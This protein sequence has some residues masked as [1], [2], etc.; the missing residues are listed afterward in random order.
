M[1]AVAA[2]LWSGKRPGLTDLVLT[3]MNLTGLGHWV[4]DFEG[5]IGTSPVLPLCFLARAAE[6]QLC[7]A[8]CPHHNVPP[9]VNGEGTMD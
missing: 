8:I 6:G 2:S 5:H 4:H 1:T 7:S 9:K 3:D